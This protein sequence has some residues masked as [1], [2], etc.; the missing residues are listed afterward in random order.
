[1]RARIPKIAL[2]LPKT[3]KQ[4]LYYAKGVLAGLAAHPEIRVEPALVRQ[5]TKEV[6]ALEKREAAVLRRTAGRVAARNAQAEVVRSTLRHVASQVAAL[7]FA[8]PENARAF[9]V[10]SGFFVRTIG[11]HAVLELEV[12]NG[13]VT[14]SVVLVA[15]SLGRNVMYCFQ[16]SLDQK[17]WLDLPP[18]NLCKQGLSGLQPGL[19][20]YFRFRPY[21]ADGRGNFS[22]IVSH[23]VQ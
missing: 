16:Y 19:L 14:G 23:R 20:Y 7:A 6:A 5:L 15:K 12:K 4:L 11:R 17:R 1:M 3:P 13:R 21:T 2:K 10:A 22:Q 18:R 8:D 9:I